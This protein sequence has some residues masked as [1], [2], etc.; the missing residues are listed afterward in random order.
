MSVTR[1]DVLHRAAT[2]WPTGSVPYSQDHLHPGTGYRQ[3]CSGFVSMCWVIPLGA[4]GS[5][6]GMNTVSL[7]TDGW[8]S[9]IEHPARALRGQTQPGPGWPGA[10]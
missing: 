6:G 9:P 5:W 3:D 8:M 10:R 4:D 1:A 7:V 2:L